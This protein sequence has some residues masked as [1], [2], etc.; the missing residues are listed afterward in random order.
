MDLFIS[1]QRAR[2]LNRKIVVLFLCASVWF[3]SP[4]RDGDTRKFCKRMALQD[5]GS[6]WRWRG[7]CEEHCHKTRLNIGQGFST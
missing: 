3:E 7:C 4:G 6:G 2:E 1:S 5:L